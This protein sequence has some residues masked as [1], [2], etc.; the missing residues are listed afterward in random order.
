[1][2]L[3]IFNY[4]EERYTLK[5]ILF[6]LDG[7]L[8]NF[9]IDYIRARS[10][11]ARV[12]EDAGFPPGKLNPNELISNMLQKARIYFLDENRLTIDQFK[13]IRQQVNDAIE[14]IEYEAAIKATPI[15]EMIKVL[16]FVRNL[17]L[18]RAVITYNTTNNARISL[19][20]AGLME[21][22][23]DS[24]IVGRDQVA[25]PKPHPDHTHF[26][27]Q[28]VNLTPDE[29]CIIGDHPRDIEAANNIGARSIALISGEHV[30][31]EY[32]T[33]FRCLKHEIPIKIP[34]FIKKFL[35]ES[36]K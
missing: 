15:E 22:F 20:T 27:L 10:A 5:G 35:N 8:I 30:P 12:L 17:G 11:T 26:I 7:T 29:I 23:D 18:I 24:Y 31:E 14:I 4:E 32:Q 28:R 13:S 21:Y 6:D 33:S 19:R 9:Q 1:L 36:I 3:R 34:D 16:D 2:T 25:N